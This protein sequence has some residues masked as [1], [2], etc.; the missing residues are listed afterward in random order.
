MAKSIFD[1][2]NSP[3]PVTA[4][5]AP[6]VLAYNTPRALTASAVRID[7]KNKKEVDAI[8]K[9]RQ[10]DKWQEEAWEYYDLIGEIK[11]VANLIASVTSRINIYAGYVE[12]SNNVPSSIDTIAKLD[13]EFVQ[14]ADDTLYLLES[15]NG[16][17]SGLLRS[18]ALNMFVTGECWLVN[19][20]ARFTTGEPSKFQIRS[21]QEI[22][23][24][25]DGNVAIKPR[26]D[27]KPAD[28]IKLP[29]GGFASRIW[30]NHPRFS[31]EADSSVRGVLDMCD[32]LLVMDRAASA[33]AKSRM[34]AGLLFV[35]DGLSA[36]TETEGEMTA[37]GDAS[38]VTE[39]D[40]SFE[41]E[42]IAGLISPIEDIS[43]AASVVP[44]I[45]RGPEEL[46]AVIRHIT[47]DRQID[48]HHELR[49]DRL[50]D[51]I[52]SGLDVPKDV[53]AGMSNV[54]YANAIVIEEQL[55]K[56]H[57]E[58]LILLIVDCL[59][60][61]F[62][63]PALLKKGWDPEIVSRAV[64]WYDPSE[65]TAKPSKAE[66]AVTLYG[67]KIISAEAVLRAN[68]FSP[69]DYPSDLERVQRMAEERAIISDAMSETL[70]NSFVPD[71]LKNQAKQQALAESDPASANALQNAVG[72]D[73][74]A[75]PAAPAADAGQAPA[76]SD[77]IE[78]TPSSNVQA[79]PT[80]MEP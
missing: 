29:P 13:P 42:L 53:A 32:Q 1:R 77:T 51:R 38:T 70:L 48:G 18:A 9:R 15:G 75:A 79:P 37:S 26:R 68:G 63:R 59:T 62:L 7:L 39:L 72:G 57:I 49:S 58:P 20:P 19:E 4:S 31:D 23:G 55:Y 54:K 52:L 71:D 6:A 5:L 24:T 80:L 25:K 46:G 22:V 17:T 60:I 56:A 3:E 67:L 45:I 47:F 14:D 10:A 28:Y 8:N 66:A 61:G 2:R 76:P 27:A 44:T 65:I 41:E 11:Y 33:S 30:R 50:L 16:G 78:P 36:I 74:P 64:V 12:K 43:S 34:N 35:P 40:E 69:E 21:V 73:Q